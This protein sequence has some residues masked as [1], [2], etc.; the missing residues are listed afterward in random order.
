MIKLILFKC[1]TQRKREAGAALLT[2]IIVII[3]LGVL[4]AALYS[5]FYTANLNQVVAQR[6]SRAFYLAESGIRIATSEYNAAPYKNAML[7][8]LH[9]KEI[10]IPDIVGKMMIK[11]NPYWF[12][13]TAADA[14]GSTTAALKL[15]LA[16]GIPPA[17]AD[18]DT[19]L[20]FPSTGFLR[21]RD[22]GRDPA[23]EGDL[24]AS[25]SGF[26]CENSCAFDAAAGGTALTFALDSPGFTDALIEGDE[27][28]IGSASYTTVQAPS[29]AGGNLTL[30]Y[31]N[32]ETATLFPPQKGMIF[33]VKGGVNSFYQYSSRVIDADAKT[34]KLTG[35]QPVTG[36]PAPNWQLN[37]LPGD[38]VYIG[39]IVGF[40]SNGAF[41]D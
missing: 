32:I 9:N 31:T 5:L 16:G 1:P 19:P 8:A 40:T 28:Y 18:T 11:S 36:A 15:H 14:A 20:T 7:I 13:A 4:S 30:G 34:I 39:R 37:L 24:F 3:V 12:H 10:I 23:W 29:G 41:G 38:Q 21:V 26:T 22:S 6:G 17:F 25:Y 27:F 33:V 35:M 2:I